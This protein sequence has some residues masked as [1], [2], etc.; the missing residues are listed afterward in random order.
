MCDGREGGQCK[1]ASQKRLGA[2]AWRAHLAAERHQ[3]QLA[4]VAEAPG[5]EHAAARDA[6]SVAV[7]AGHNGGGDLL[8]HVGVVSRLREVGGK[9]VFARS[10]WLDRQPK[11]AVAKHKAAGIRQQAN[12]GGMQV[13]CASRG[14]TEHI[15]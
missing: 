3:A 12:V 10:T 15:W 6:G 9:H 4:A 1:L 11:V 13:L 8:L 2:H 5:V 7:A 14:L